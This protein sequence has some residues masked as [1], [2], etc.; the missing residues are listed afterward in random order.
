ML[1]FESGVEVD[2]PVEKIYFKF[3]YYFNFSLNYTPIS[4]ICFYLRVA[5][6]T[7]ANKQEILIQCNNPDDKKSWYLL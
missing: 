5:M 1:T 6:E 4:G 7:V 2:V 3:L